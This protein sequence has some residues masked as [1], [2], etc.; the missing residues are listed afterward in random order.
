MVLNVS[1]RIQVSFALCSYFSKET[2]NLFFLQIDTHIQDNMAFKQFMKEGYW[3]NDAQKA[4]VAL[5]NQTGEGGNIRYL[6][7]IGLDYPDIPS[8]FVMN[9]EFGDFGPARKE[10]QE[11]SGIQNYNF[12]LSAEMLGEMKM[13]GVVNETG[14]RYTLWGYSNKLE[15]S[16][17]LNDEELQKIKDDRDPVETPR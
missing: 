6:N 7:L 8:Q 1:L 2:E 17:W 3:A 16:W 11:A 14:D 10:V 15:Q 5:Y 13:P 12:Q 9:V 4:F